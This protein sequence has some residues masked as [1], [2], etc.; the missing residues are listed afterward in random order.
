MTLHSPWNPTRDGRS[1]ALEGFREGQ[2]WAQQAP[3]PL[4][5]AQ[6]TGAQLAEYPFPVFCG[7]FV[8]PWPDYFLMVTF[9]L[10]SGPGHSLQWDM[11]G[12]HSLRG[13]GDQR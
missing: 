7:M 13:G 8:H 12:T 3:F 9:S 1:Q 2:S 10:F 4:S 6:L 11:G 5:G